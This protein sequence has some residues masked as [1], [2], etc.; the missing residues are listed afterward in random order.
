[1]KSI[2]LLANSKKRKILILGDMLELG[3]MRKYM[4]KNIGSYA[5]QKKIDI[6]I[7]FGN[8]TKYAVEEFGKS[9]VYFSNENELKIFLKKNISSKDTVLLKGSRGMQ[10]EKFINV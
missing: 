9:G 2:D 4:H 5:L 1:M 3:R 8:L 10:M 6:L 7:G